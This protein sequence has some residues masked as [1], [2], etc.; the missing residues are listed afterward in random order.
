MP[1][2]CVGLRTF[3]A[4]NDV[5]FHLIA[6]FQR[7]VSV[8]LDSGVMYEDIRSVF[9]TDKAE[10]FGVVEPLDCAFVLSHRISPFLFL[11]AGDIWGSR[12]LLET[13]K[14]C[15]KLRRISAVISRNRNPETAIS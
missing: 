11:K 15:E 12:L 9:P 2:N 3:L 6:L 1:G 14:V 4:V 13:Q 10:A 8:H 7:L 5:E